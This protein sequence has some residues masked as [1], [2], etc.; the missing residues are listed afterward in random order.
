MSVV[1]GYSL[2]IWRSV[3]YSNPQVHFIFRVGEDPNKIRKDTFPNPSM[4]IPICK[5]ANPGTKLSVRNICVLSWLF[6]GGKVSI[7][8]ENNLQVH[9][10]DVKHKI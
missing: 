2:K 10:I 8:I 9:T 4:S 7:G 1:R 5:P 6:V 3:K